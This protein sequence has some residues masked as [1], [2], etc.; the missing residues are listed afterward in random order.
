MWKVAPPFAA[1]LSSDT[2]AMFREGLLNANSTVLELGTGI[3]PVAAVLVGR[4]VARYI[5]SDQGYVLKL[6]RENIHENHRALRKGATGATAKANAKAKR[7]NNG[8]EENERKREG[9]GVI[10]VVSL[11]WETDD[12]PSLLR[13]LNA[14]VDVVLVSDCVFNEFLI[15]PLVSTCAAVCRGEHGQHSASAIEHVS[16]TE[17]APASAICIVAQQLRDADVFEAWLVRM[18][19][20][21]R[22]WR[23]RREELSEDLQ[24]GF[25]VHVAV[26]RLSDVG[27]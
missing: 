2:T 7:V 12:V 13:R 8:S 20:S 14:H 5:A 27:D 19:L 26:P 21:F 25:I 16:A 3:S 9:E 6:L 23:V 10:E 15:E 1:W 24:E 18:L 11:D 4:R 22:V 17:S